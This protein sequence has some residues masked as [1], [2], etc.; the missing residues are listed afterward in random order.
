MHASP[1]QLNLGLYS[2]ELDTANRG[3]E[4]TDLA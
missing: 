1:S 4:H 3:N 2:S